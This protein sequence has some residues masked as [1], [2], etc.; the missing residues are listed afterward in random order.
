M[1]RLKARVAAK[2]SSQ[3]QGVGYL[4][5]F[6]RTSSSESVRMPAIGKRRRIGDISF[7]IRARF[8]SHD[9]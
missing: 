6:A 9:T 2:G 8:C 5:T 3:V 1:V 4:E 7:G